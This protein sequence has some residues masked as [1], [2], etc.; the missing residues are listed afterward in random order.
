MSII[1]IHSNFAFNYGFTRTNNL[2]KEY[3]DAIVEDLKNRNCEAYYL[4]H[5]NAI[6]AQRYT[7]YL[8]LNY[9][10]EFGRS[11]YEND[12]EI[13]LDIEDK[14]LIKEDIKV[15]KDMGYKI[16]EDKS[17]YGYLLI[18]KDSM[19]TN[20]TDALITQIN[21]FNAEFTFEICSKD[22]FPCDRCC[23]IC[24]SYNSCEFKEKDIK[25]F[26]KEEKDGMNNIVT[27]STIYDFYESL[28]EGK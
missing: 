20:D 24:K 17:N 3:I 12:V 14:L 7:N 21:K 8:A 4:D 13:E 6:F 22:G 9:R 23:D 15:L 28:K 10:W 11:E 26:K 18:Y 1:E 27:A 5:K 19:N 2:K 25:H 16:I